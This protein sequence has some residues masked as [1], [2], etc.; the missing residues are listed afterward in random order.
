MKRPGDGS[1]SRAPRP[2]LVAREIRSR[3]TVDALSL[4]AIRAVEKKDD[5]DGYGQLSRPFG[6]GI[7]HDDLAAPCE[8]AGDPAALR[9]FPHRRHRRTSLRD[10]LLRADLPI[11]RGPGA[12][13]P[14][15]L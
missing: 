12:A 2:G 13:R 1:G 3:P 4:R 9:G 5:R 8:R 14:G 11:Y 6:R 15:A 10:R 7:R